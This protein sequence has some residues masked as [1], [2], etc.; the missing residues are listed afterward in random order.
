MSTCWHTEAFSFQFGCY[1]SFLFFDKRP[2]LFPL[3]IV[4]ALSQVWHAFWDSGLFRAIPEGRSVLHFLP[5]F[6]QL[7]E[8]SLSML[9]LL[10]DRCQSNSSATQALLSLLGMFSLQ[11]P[12]SYFAVSQATV[13]PSFPPRSHAL[14]LA[15]FPEVFFFLRIVLCSFEQPRITAA[16]VPVDCAISM[17]LLLGAPFELNRESLYRKNHCAQKDTLAGTTRSSVK[18]SLY[19]CSVRLI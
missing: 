11:N 14:N 19:F 16:C 6:S 5:H 17:R 18:S 4:P 1:C 3:A 2:V 7:L 15:F 12:H 9:W 13:F 10:T 8:D